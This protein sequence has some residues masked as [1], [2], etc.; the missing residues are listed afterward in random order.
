MTT[1]I[2]SHMYRVF[3]SLGEVW[4]LKEN[5]WI[6]IGISLKLVPWGLVDN[7]LSLALVWIDSYAYR[8][9]WVKLDLILMMKSTNCILSFQTALHWAAKHGNLDVI[10]LLCGNGNIQINAQ[11]VSSCLGDGEINGLVQDCSNSIADALESLQSCTKPLKYGWTCWNVECM[12]HQWHD[13]TKLSY[14]EKPLA[15]GNQSR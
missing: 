5:E 2:R 1:L 3:P 6:L 8:P 7:I 11:S 10:K 14:T 9:Q 15:W 4:Y 12:T 13:D